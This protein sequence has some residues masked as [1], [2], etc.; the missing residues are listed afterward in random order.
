MSLRGSFGFALLALWAVG[1]PAVARAD[2]AQLGGQFDAA[3]ASRSAPAII[4]ANKA[5]EDSDVCDLD[6]H[7]FLRRAL[8]GVI[9]ALANAPGAAAPQDTVD[10]L[11]AKLGLSG[12]WRSAE[13]LGKYFDS[14][15]DRRSAQLAYELAAGLTGRNIGAAATL[16]DL[17]RLSNEAFAAKSLASFDAERQ[18]E[19]P[20][21]KSTRAAG[22]EITIYALAMRTVG[23]GKMPAPVNFI[24]D[25]TAMTES[26]K[27]AAGELAE[28]AMQQRLSRF[29]LIG[30]AD[31]RGDAAYNLKLSLG[32]AEVLKRAVQ[33]AIAAAK[34]NYL[35]AHPMPEIEVAGKGAAEPFDLSYLPYKPSLDETYQLDRRVE[36][37]FRD[38]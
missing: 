16:D 26:G 34:D 3:I 5:V 35:G 6:A 7:A 24:Y 37:E 18:T 31:P 38:P 36:F 12:D 14:R 2:C 22:G 19:K 25:S 17:K 30:H 27:A 33:E 1:S 32:R 8:N 28:V 13:R 29:R 23:I 11:F 20:Y 4:A 9:E 21:P 10:W 15:G